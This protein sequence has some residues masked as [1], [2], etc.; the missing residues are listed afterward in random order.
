MFYGIFALPLFGESKPIPILNTPYAEGGARLSPNG[1]WLAYDS[2]E[3][4]RFEVYVRPFPDPGGKWQVSSE[5]GYNPAWSGDG[6][7]LF[8]RAPGFRMMAVPVET[9]GTF[10]AG[11]PVQLFDV[12]PGRSIFGGEYEV[13]DDGQR[14]LFVLRAGEEDELKPYTVVLNW[15]A[16]LGEQ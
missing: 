6:K 2:N 5:G 16:E 11:T 13:A 15:M 3:S 10:E 7:E 1:R 14:F 8:Y 4:G 12:R 9:E